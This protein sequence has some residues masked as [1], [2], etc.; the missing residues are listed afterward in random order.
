M[1][2]DWSTEHLTPNFA[3]NSFG[4]ELQHVKNIYGY[5]LT[6]VA[7]L[8][9]LADD[10]ATMVARID[11]VQALLATEMSASVADANAFTAYAVGG[12]ANLPQGWIDATNDSVTGYTSVDMQAVA[13][14]VEAYYQA[15]VLTNNNLQELR[16]YVTVIDV[17]NFKLHMELLSGVD[18]APPPGII[19]PN[20]PSLMGLAIGLIE[21]E[22]R[23]GVSFVRFPFYKADGTL[24]TSG[25]FGGGGGT[26]ILNFYRADGTLDTI[27]ISDGNFPF[28][29]ADG[30]LDGIITSFDFNN[31]LIGLF[32]TLF[33]GDVTIAAA[34]THLDTDPLSAG[35]YGPLGIS[36]G[37]NKPYVSGATGEDVIW[38]NSIVAPKVAPLSVPVL[39]YNAPLITTHKAALTTHIVDDMAYYD[40]CTAK[41]EAIMRAYGISGH[42][43]DPFYAYMYTDV[44]GTAELNVVISQFLNGEIE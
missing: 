33:T 20:N 9:P 42:I 38:N 2:I 26:S 27:E 41:I 11:A 31:H 16:D 10:I 15:C 7:Y 35:T 4:A 17:D 14:T 22:N 32:N 12:G 18:D 37:V 40:E 44:F 21:M 24:D 29:R 5:L 23:F 6:D 13:S 34:Q 28:Y 25:N 3:A 19:K 30:T 43:Q 36:A 39:L 8:N 1:P